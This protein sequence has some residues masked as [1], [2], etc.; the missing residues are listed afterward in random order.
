MTSRVLLVVNVQVGLLP[1]LPDADTI[2]ANVANV[3]EHARRAEHTP[4]IIHL[5]NCGEAGDPDEEGTDTWQ[6]LH[7]PLADE[8]V[9]DKRKSNAFAGT[10]LGEHISPEAEIVVVG[11]LSEFSIK[12]TC[13][14]AMNR[15]NTVLLIQGAHGTYDHTDLVEEGRVIPAEKIK[16]QVETELDK[17]GAMV[18]DMSY[19]PGLFDGR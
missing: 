5:R 16:A 11:L 7:T 8:L 17:A 10:T 6:L 2:V 19:L 9:L 15:G 14:A 1:D 18:L 13:M 3:L 12:S 4:R